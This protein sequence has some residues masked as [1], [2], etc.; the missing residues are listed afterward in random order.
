MLAVSR[1]KPT[2]CRERV[3]FKSLGEECIS[4]EV[5]AIPSKVWGVCETYTTA[6]TVRCSRSWERPLGFLDQSLSLQ[7]STLK[8][9]YTCEA[10]L[11]EKQPHLQMHEKSLPMNN[12]IVLVFVAWHIWVLVE[13]AL[14]LQ[15]CLRTHQ[16]PRADADLRTDALDQAA[17]H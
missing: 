17:E 3:D 2:V 14:G 8:A 9:Y 15:A 7:D 11:D 1:S 12:P 4:M 5:W 13:F 16:G 6:P 10:W